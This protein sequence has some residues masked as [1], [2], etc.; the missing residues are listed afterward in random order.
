MAV[1]PVRR[2]KASW[3]RQLSRMW[4]IPV[5]A[6]I[7]QSEKTADNFRTA[8]PFGSTPK[9][10]TISMEKGSKTKT[11]ILINPKNPGKTTVAHELGH[12]AHEQKS[13]PQ[14]I[15]PL[16]SL[17]TNNGREKLQLTEFFA[18]TSEFEYCKRFEKEKYS[19]IIAENQA[20]KGISGAK[21][22][23]WVAARFLAPFQTPG[24]E[25]R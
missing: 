9:G 20:S 19:Q 11:M 10:E 18:R 5:R 8:T 4:G 2:M 22:G 6:R 25:T 24:K 13:G 17:L 15:R 3:G 21:D 7:T 14:R 16:K 23:R 1:K 12:A